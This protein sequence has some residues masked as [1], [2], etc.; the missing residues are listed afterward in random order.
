MHVVA[1]EKTGYA[2]AN[3]KMAYLSESLRKETYFPIPDFVVAV[4]DMIHG[5][6]QEKL[7]PDIEKFLELRGELPCPFYPAVGNH[8]NIQKEGDA[9]REGPYWETFGRDH[10]N[11]TFEHGGIFFIVI[12]DSGA[13]ASNARE[14]GKVRKQWMQKVLEE[15]GDQPKFICAHIPLVPVREESVLAKSFGFGSYAAH[16]RYI[17]GNPSERDFE[18]AITGNVL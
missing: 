15:S 17:K 1:Q 12:N 16:E 2:L 9:E 18:I 13:P 4:G 11:Y 5:T 8:E 14:S 6:E 10:T 7:A 3:E